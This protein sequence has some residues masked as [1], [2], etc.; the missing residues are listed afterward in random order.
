[1]TLFVMR[2]HVPGGTYFGLEP[3][4]TSSFREVL[5]RVEAGA[6]KPRTFAERFSPALPRLLPPGRGWSGEFSGRAA[7]P[8]DT[9]IRVVLGR[10]EV[11]GNVPSGFFVGF[12]CI[13]ERFVRLR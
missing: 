7:L 11:A 8:A 5:E 10:F 3:F 1:M 4:R 12:L 13:S 2:P 9:P 6:A